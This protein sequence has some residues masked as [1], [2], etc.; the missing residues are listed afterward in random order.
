[1][2]HIVILLLN[3]VSS[4]ATLSFIVVWTWGANFKGVGL[5][6]ERP[7]YV[8]QAGSVHQSDHRPFD[9]SIYEDPNKPEFWDDGGDGITPRPFRH[10]AAYPTPENANR[11]KRWQAHQI[12]LI[13][14]VGGEL[15]SNNSPAE[16]LGNGNSEKD[17]GPNLVSN[18]VKVDDW[19]NVKVA[20]IFRSDCP[21][22]RKS[23]NVVDGLEALGADVVRL[24][25][26]EIQSNKS[27]EKIVQYSKDFSQHFPY[28][29]T[30][31][32]YLKVGSKPAEKVEGYHSLYALY[33]HITNSMGG[34]RRGS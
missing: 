30:P 15:G 13:N 31:T 26:D 33:S 17:D 3:A 12:A 21:A 32:F 22:C 5:T 34:K 16:L 8:V 1:M 19:K 2:K 25:T 23:Q 7:L 4:F 29:V 28:E 20:Y 6:Q 24:Q 11:L 27:S 9:W 18:D 10:L 14:D